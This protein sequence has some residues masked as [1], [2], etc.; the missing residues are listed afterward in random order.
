MLTNY[1]KFCKNDLFTITIT[2]E[3]KYTSNKCLLQIFD[4]I[5]VI[6]FHFIVIVEIAKLLIKAS[7]VKVSHAFF[8]FY[9][10]QKWNYDDPTQ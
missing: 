6:K 1:V 2:I 7:I 10:K 9:Q 8:Y 3:S 4:K 5:P